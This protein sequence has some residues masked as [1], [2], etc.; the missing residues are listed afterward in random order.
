MNVDKIQCDACGTTQ[1]ETGADKCVCC[2]ERTPKSKQK[3]TNLVYASLL[4]IAIVL[5]IQSRNN[6]N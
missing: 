4:A 3:L 1:Y 2:G 5:I 6:K